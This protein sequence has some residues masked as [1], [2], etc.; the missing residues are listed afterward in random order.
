[1]SFKISSMENRLNKN[2]EESITMIAKNLQKKGKSSQRNQ[3][4]IKIFNLNKKIIREKKL[5]KTNNPH[6]LKT[7]N[8]N[9]NKHQMKQKFKKIHHNK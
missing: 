5:F 8:K 1:M 3:H 6:R 7:M 2:I 4:Q 9:N